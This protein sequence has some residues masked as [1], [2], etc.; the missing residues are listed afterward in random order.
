MCA[1]LGGCVGTCE[2]A[3]VCVS[4]HVVGVQECLQRGSRHSV[5]THTYPAGTEPVITGEGTVNI[6]LWCGHS[7][8]GVLGS[9]RE[10]VR[11]SFP[12]RV[13]QASVPS[14]PPIWVVESTQGIPESTCAG[15]AGSMTGAVRGKSQEE[16]PSNVRPAHITGFHPGGPGEQLQE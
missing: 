16:A 7:S 10:A 15:R 6:L 5:R 4:V 9:L 1:P 12:G 8:E 14:N 2:C 13:P 11:S 3:G